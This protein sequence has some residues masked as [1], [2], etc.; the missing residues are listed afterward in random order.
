MR[1]LPVTPPPL[2]LALGGTSGVISYGVSSR[3]YE[4]G[5]RMAV[6]AE[7]RDILRLVVGQGLRLVI[8][9]VAAGLAGALALTR[10]LTSMLYGV[11]ATD[12]ATFLAITGLLTGAALLASFIPARRAAGVDPALAMRCE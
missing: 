6:G 8:V 4:I 10:V 2:V 11:T 1:P 3:R 12:P 9:G 7:R 5:L